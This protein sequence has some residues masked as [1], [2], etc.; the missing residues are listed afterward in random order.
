M[1]GGGKKV[2]KIIKPIKPILKKSDQDFPKFDINTK[3]FYE[4]TN[5]VVKLREIF[6]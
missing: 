6:L 4:M 3:Y 5:K 1:G 2:V